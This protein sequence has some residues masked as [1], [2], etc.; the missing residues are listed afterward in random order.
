MQSKLLSLFKPS[1]LLRGDQC[2]GYRAGMQ[3]KNMDGAG[4]SL[5]C[6]LLVSSSWD[7]WALGGVQT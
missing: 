4:H 3:V 5:P 2:S 1:G 7:P 6:L